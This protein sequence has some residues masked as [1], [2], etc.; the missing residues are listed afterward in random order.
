MPYRPTIIINLPIIPTGKRLVT[1]EMDLVVFDSGKT[2][3]RSFSLDV[4]ETISLVPALGKDVEGDLAT[5]GV[6][7]KYRVS[8]GKSTWFRW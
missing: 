7:V 2:R 4:L 6:A 1:K 5:Y 3:S 8:I